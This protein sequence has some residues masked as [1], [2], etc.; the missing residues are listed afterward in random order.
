[1]HVNLRIC[2]KP[3]AFWNQELWN[4]ESE[5]HSVESLCGPMDSPW[6]SP[7]RNIGVGRF[8]LLQGTFPTQG[9]NPG[10]Q[11]CRWNLYQLSHRGSPRIVEWVAY[12]FSRGSSWL[13]NQ[14]GVSCFAGRFFTKWAIKE[15]LVWRYS[16]PFRLDIIMLFI[17]FLF[18]P[19]SKLR[20]WCGLGNLLT[21][22]IF[23][24][25]I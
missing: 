17:S 10:L 14:T 1:M 8:S 15:A 23:K 11:H 7:G 3:K 5:I 4:T 12:P 20:Y 6:N 13:R 18:F 25:E 22:L 2:Y 16:T 24:A 19:F 9:S 21:S